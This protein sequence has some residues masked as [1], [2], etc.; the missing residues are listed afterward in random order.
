MLALTVIYGQC[1]FQKMAAHSLNLF[2]LQTFLRLRYFILSLKPP[3]NRYRE[4]IYGSAL[5][6]RTDIAEQDILSGCDTKV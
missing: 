2:I 6:S 5:C 4:S 3:V 1:I